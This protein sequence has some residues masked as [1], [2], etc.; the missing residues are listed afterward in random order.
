MKR[1]IRFR[2]WDDRAKH[3]VTDGF[4][5]YPDG[6]ME[7]PEGG[8]DLHGQ[9]DGYPLM[10]FTGLK[11][12][13]GNDIYEGDICRGILNYPGELFLNDPP[14]LVDEV[15]EIRMHEFMWL[16]WDEDEYKQGRIDRYD[17][18]EVIGNIY[19]NPDLLKPTN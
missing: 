10:Q 3:M 5:I 19:E 17:T 6:K 8:W 18:I 15:G 14:N 4:V 12:K 2:A 13:R 11:D 16:L 7:F 9:D 1:E